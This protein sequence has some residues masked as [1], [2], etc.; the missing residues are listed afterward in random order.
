MNSRYS[1]E[2]Y[3]L[4]GA[5]LCGIGASMFWASEAVIPIGYPSENER[6]RMAGIWMAIRQCGP[7]IV[8][9]VFVPQAPIFKLVA[10]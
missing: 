1:I 9:S 10:H 8:S 2:W 4:F 7:L 6:G 5:A 3:V